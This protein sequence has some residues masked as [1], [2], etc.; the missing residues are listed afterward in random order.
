[1]S[2]VSGLRQK[3]IEA[4]IDAY[5]YDNWCHEGNCS[6]GKFKWSNPASAYDLEVAYP[7]GEWSNPF[8][9]ESLMEHLPGYKNEFPIPFD[10]SLLFST[11]ENSV[12]SILDPWSDLPR[13]GDFEGQNE[14]LAYVVTKLSSGGS[15]DVEGDGSA[16][17][18]KVGN[19]ELDVYVSTITS[20]LADLDGEAMTFL[21]DYF[22]SRIRPTLAGQAALA[23]VARTAVIGEAEAWG[24]ANDDVEKLVRESIK[25]FTA[26][27]EGSSMDWKETIEVTGTVL[28]VLGMA[29]PGLSAVN[30]IIGVVGKVVPN[31][32]AKKNFDI[33][34]STA[35]ELWTSF[36]EGLNDLRHAISDTE[37]EF[38][39]CASRAIDTSTSNPQLFNIKEPSRFLNSGAPGVYGPGGGIPATRIHIDDALKKVSA[40]FELIG[41]LQRDMANRLTDAQSSGP[42]ARSFDVATRP[43]GHYPEYE[44]LLS[45]A[46]DL[47]IE[48][49]R[50]M[51]SIAEKCMVVLADFR[52]T[53]AQVESD[54][55][56]FANKVER[57]VQENV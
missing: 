43:T 50:E 45:R 15:V 31:E 3:M 30:T 40:R 5:M 51:H 57:E 41:D 52:D 48:S 49:S 4:V 44:A 36:N 11:I 20:E 14:V 32:P 38:A 8:P 22:A 47:L 17:D 46:T 9:L 35:D 55:N 54:L 12:T 25:A 16:T 37:Q 21:R 7:S 26:H 10:A 19:A 34:G 23:A 28:S 6:E 33:S 24:R 18:L 42:W 1:M 2:G 56:R 29:I 27:A 13:K 53:D 39:D